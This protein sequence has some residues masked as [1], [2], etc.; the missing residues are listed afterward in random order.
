MLALEWQVYGEDLLQG[1]ELIE[2][3]KKGNGLEYSVII[4]GTNPKNKK[5][6]QLGYIVAVED[7]IDEDD[8]SIYL[9]DF[10]VVP[11]AQ[12]QGVGW[13]LLKEFVGKLKAKAAAKG[14][15]ILWDMHLR[16]GSQKLLEKHHDDLVR[17]GL[18]VLEEA[19]VPDYYDDGVDALY[20]VYR[21]NS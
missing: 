21:I 14:E 5:E 6:Q 20:K 12:G 3:I 13:E 7:K 8:P 11:D 16:E 17:L 1:Q 15:P 4:S 2:D 9:E 18:E 19:V 10:A